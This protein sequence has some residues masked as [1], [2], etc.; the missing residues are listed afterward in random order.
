[1]RHIILLNIILLCF[2][3]LASAK[4]EKFRSWYYECTETNQCKIYTYF[5]I[6]KKVADDPD[7][8]AYVL[9]VHPDSTITFEEV[10][11]IGFHNEIRSEKLPVVY[12]IS[13]YKVVQN[14]NPLDFH[15]D[16]PIHIKVGDMVVQSDRCGS[17]CIFTANENIEKIVAMFLSS[18]NADVYRAYKDWKT[19]KPYDKM[20]ATISLMGF[21]KAYKK[22]S[23]KSNV[24]GGAKKTKEIKPESAID[25]IKEN[26]KNNKLGVK[27]TDLLAKKNLKGDGYFVYVEKTKYSGYER[28]I[29][30]YVIGDNAIKLNSPS[31]MVTPELPWPREI[32]EDS[33]WG[34]AGFDKSDVTKEALRQVFG[35]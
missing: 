30:W 20:L 9:A 32:H 21:T 3:T 6:P 23:P 12:T 25:L 33:V 26:I 7:L 19:G 4:V 15:K 17:Y 29:V 22:L 31:S 24:G 16:Y 18:T 5:K 35:R 28:L 8:H 10:W 1:M 2:S 13:G 11:D 27:G 34:H 14:N